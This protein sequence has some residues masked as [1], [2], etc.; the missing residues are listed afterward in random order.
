MITHVRARIYV[1]D[2]TELG[3]ADFDGYFEITLLKETKNL[4]FG[5]PDYEWATVP[6]PENCEYLEV[7]LL[8]GGCCDFMSS[9]KIDRLRKK[10]FQKLPKLHQE[11]F[12]KGIFKTEKPC[13]SQVFTPIKPRLDE[14]AKKMKVITKRNKRDFEKLSVGDT[15]KIPFSGDH[16]T[17][18]AGRTSL[19]VNSYLSGGNNF[20]CVIEGVIIEKYKNR[21][22]YYLEFKVTGTGGCK[23]KSPTYNYK[24]VI[25]GL[26]FK[27]NMKHF[28]VL[29]E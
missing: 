16:S 2:T 7:I 23:Y 26:I 10:W 24:D 11:A 21:K 19:Y 28:K 3:R 5:A 8:R 13:V 12:Q 4:K 14:I 25:A 17:D 22:G 9:R 18:A 29:I 1:N 27:Y 20:D 6:A 15:I